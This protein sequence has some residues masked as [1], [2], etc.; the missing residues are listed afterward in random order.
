M[1]WTK[2]D[3]S[4]SDPRYSRVMEREDLSHVSMDCRTTET[5]IRYCSEVTF[6][7]REEKRD[8]NIASPF[9][10]VNAHLS[11]GVFGFHL[12]QTTKMKE[13][14]EDAAKLQKESSSSWTFDLVSQRTETTRRVTMT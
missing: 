14:K 6:S 10:V 9:D 3:P 13:S 1:P 7:R 11:F 12:A 5:P 8:F 4:R 2:E